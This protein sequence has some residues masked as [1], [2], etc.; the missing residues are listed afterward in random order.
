MESPPELLLTAGGSA[1]YDVVVAE[2]ATPPPPGMRVV[3]RS[4]AY[5]TYD[6]GMYAGLSPGDAL[7]GI[8]G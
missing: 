2:L 8:P 6:H 3:L 1:F 4:G 5:I 7:D